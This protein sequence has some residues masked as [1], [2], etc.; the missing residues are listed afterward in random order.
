MDAE[1]A[2]GCDI[3]TVCVVVQLLLSVMV[4]VYVP[5]A[6]EFAVAAVPPEGAQLYVYGVVPP[7]TETVAAPL[8]PPLQLTLVCELILLLSA[9]GCVK[10]TVCVV[11]QLL[12]SVIVQVY[13]PAA[14]EFAV[15]AVPP[16]GA[17]L[18]EY[19]VVPPVTETVADPFVPPLQLI[20]VC[21]LIVA[22]R[23]DGCVIETV[24]VFTHELLSVIVHVY[25]PAANEFAVA[26]VP[27]AGAQLYEYGVVPPVTKTVADPFVPPLQLTFVCEP[28]LLL[29]AAGCV[30][31]TVCVFT[32]PLKSVMVQV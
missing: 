12:L 4:H 20:F 24:C 27:P 30:S 8:F 29:R 28:I 2:P 11:E 16:A 6:N 32:H 7:E 18:Y 14:N 19:G 9:E 21:A 17:Q 3:E 1:S 31:V 22:E 23:P 5:A 10:L 13:V 26:A 15:A 25:V